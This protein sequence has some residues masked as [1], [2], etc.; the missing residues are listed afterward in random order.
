[1]NRCGG[2][3]WLRCQTASAERVL[4]GSTHGYA[5]R[6]APSC[7]TGSSRAALWRTRPLDLGR[8]LDAVHMRAQVTGYRR[9]CGFSECQRGGGKGARGCPSTRPPRSLTLFHARCPMP[10]ARCPMPRT[11]SPSLPRNALPLLV[12]QSLP[13]RTC[14]PELHPFPPSPLPS[15]NTAVDHGCTP[16]QP[17]RRRAGCGVRGVGRGARVRAGR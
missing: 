8:C 6:A 9:R 4:A 1:M 10:D 15:T 5:P 2:S 14:A 7:R 16:R 12:H 17:R 3:W 11:V 13:T